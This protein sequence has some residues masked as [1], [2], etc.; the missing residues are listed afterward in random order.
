[1]NIMIWLM[2]DIG[3]N[4]APLN[5]YPASINSFDPSWTPDGQLILFSQNKANSGIPWLIARRLNDQT[6]TG[7]FRIPA[8]GQDIGPVAGAN[9]SPDGLWIV[10]ESWP[11][12]K[13]HDIFLITING[14]DR[15]QLTNDAAFDF[16]PAFR[17]K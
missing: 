8:S 9:I 4:Q 16:S 7:G 6:T 12:G 17:R 1:V 13:N 10:Y 15:T 14:T 5:L 11:D 3:Q 2:S